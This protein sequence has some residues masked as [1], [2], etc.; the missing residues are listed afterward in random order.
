MKINFFFAILLNYLVVLN[1]YTFSE[2]EVFIELKIENEII[3]NIDI[4][5]EKNYLIALNNKLENLNNDQL[6]NLAKD[7]LIREKIKKVELEKTFDLKKNDNLTNVFI[8]NLY[9]NLNL[10][11][12]KEFEDYLD[13]Y[14]LKIKDISEKIL[15]E[16]LWNKL[17]FQKFNKNLIIN[18]ENLKKQLKDQVKKNK[19]EEFNLKEIMFEL[20]AN[21]NLKQKSKHILDFIKKNGFENAANIFSISDSSKF[22]GSLGWI[23][24]AQIS[25]NILNEINDAQIGEITKP[26]QVN[27]TYLILKLENKRKKEVKIN[28]EKELEKLIIYEKEKQL[29]NYSLMFFNKVKKNIYINES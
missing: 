21:E 19:L 11:N 4:N 26:I 9:K 16:R 2:N 27:S 12:I 28:I 22:G 13:A 7:S 8:K 29:N 14:N 5:Y 25:K 15:I 6:Y 18:K 20:K 23:N 3:T 24:K 10:N 1:S 17:I